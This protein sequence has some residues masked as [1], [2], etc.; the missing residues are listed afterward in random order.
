M[1]RVWPFRGSRPPSGGVARGG[2]DLKLP[3]EG[4]PSAGAG[5]RPPL[6]PPSGGAGFAREKGFSRLLA[7]PRLLDRVSCQYEI[8]EEPAA[9]AGPRDGARSEQRGG[10]GEETVTLAQ[11][12]A[13]AAGGTVE[14]LRG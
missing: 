14:P 4:Q 5:G 6:R 9:T 1:E 10:A 11:V 3:R 7:G 8:L 13:G 12:A 2:A